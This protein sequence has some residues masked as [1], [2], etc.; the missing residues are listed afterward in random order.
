MI[1]KEEGKVSV[2]LVFAEGGERESDS[3]GAG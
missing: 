3:D 1:S 2:D